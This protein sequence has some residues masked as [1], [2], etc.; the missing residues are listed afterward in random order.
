V[1]NGKAV[2][3]L[4]LKFMT[5][6]P[7]VA[8]TYVVKSGDNLDAIARANGYR[9]WQVIYKSQCNTRLRTLR[10]NPNLIKPGDLVYLPPRAAD[11]RATLQKRLERLRAARSDAEQLFDGLQREM[12]GE[13][14]KLEATSTTVDA[15]S[16]VLGIL[17]GLGRLCWRGYKAIELGGEEL[18]KANKELAKEALDMP[19]DQF[20]TV[21]LKT[22]ADQLDQ[23]QTVHLMNSVWMFSATVVR[24][25]LDITSPSYWAGVVAE[26]RQG[27]SLR[28]AV[29]RRPADVHASASVK[30]AGVRR[31]ALQQIDAKLRETERLLSA[32][33]RDISAPLPLE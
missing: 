5:L 13:F 12:D 23:P 29:T 8:K 14:R 18:T 7:L 32:C 15:A 27:S 3:L 31:T 6:V 10:P 9:N 20:E 17:V 19:K 26:L 11:I 30:L 33:G 28:T 25:W 1:V 24:S 22:F 2:S 16:E 4:D 21:T